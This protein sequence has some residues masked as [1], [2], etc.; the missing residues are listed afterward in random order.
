MSYEV[1]SSEGADYLMK[2]YLDKVKGQLIDISLKDKITHLEKEEFTDGKY[3]VTVWAKNAT[4]VFLKGDVSEIAKR[5]GLIS[6]FEALK[7]R[8]Q[9]L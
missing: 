7:L 8:D 1:Y 6:P 2:F 3:R 5:L 9:H 4:R